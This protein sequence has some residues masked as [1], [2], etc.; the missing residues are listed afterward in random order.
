MRDYVSKLVDSPVQEYTFNRP[1]VALPVVV[2]KDYRSV[3]SI[4]SPSAEFISRPREK[5]ESLAGVSTQQPI[6]LSVS[7]RT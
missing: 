1:P 4:S 5:L 2:A 7:F 3:S 6:F